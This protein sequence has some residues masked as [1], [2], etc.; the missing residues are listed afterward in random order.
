MA[1]ASNRRPR[2]RRRRNPKKR[3]VVLTD[4]EAGPDD[5]Q[6]LV[7]LL[8]YSNDLDLEALIATTS[9]H[10]KQR[11]APESIRKIISAYGKVQPNL[12]KH[13]KEFPTAQ[14]LL[15]S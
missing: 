7:R 13:D 12:L 9:T 2:Q 4:V 10:Q 3:V 14:S 1:S 8:L 5:A 15:P 11:V 6:S